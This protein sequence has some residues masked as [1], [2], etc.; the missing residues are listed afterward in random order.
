MGFRYLG[1]MII[2]NERIWK[3]GFISNEVTKEEFVMGNATPLSK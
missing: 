1:W 3:G 2:A